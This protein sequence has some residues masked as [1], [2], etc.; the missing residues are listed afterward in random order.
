MW[1]TVFKPLGALLLMTARSS[2]RADQRAKCSSNSEPQAVSHSWV[3]RTVAR[4]VILA[5]ACECTFSEAGLR[6][7]VHPIRAIQADVAAQEADS[8]SITSSSMGP[9]RLNMT[10][11]TVRQMLPKASFERGTDG[12]GAALIRVTFGPDDSLVLWAGEEDPEAPID[13][14]RQVITISTFSGT[15]HTVDGIRPGSLV[16]D[17]SRILGPIHEVVV[18]EIES[19]QFI[20]FTRQPSWLTFRLDYT[21][22]FPASARRTARVQPG[23]RILAIYISLHEP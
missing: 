1:P 4:G 8:R 10:L 14:S 3:S 6:A 17:V 22:I 23:A 12:D 9:V 13:W 18:S 16:S 7:F 19:R 5:C 21:G 2:T 20:T 11:G 15:F